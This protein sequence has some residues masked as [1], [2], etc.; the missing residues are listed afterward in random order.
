[1][2]ICELTKIEFQ[3]IIHKHPCVHVHTYFKDEI[4]KLTKISVHKL[5][6]L[7]SLL[8]MLHPFHDH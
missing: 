1:M 6:P 4:C 7:S 3:I 2:E 5:S 8:T